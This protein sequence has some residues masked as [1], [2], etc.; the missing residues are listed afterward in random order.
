MTFDPQLAPEIEDDPACRYCDE[1]SERDDLCY[2]HWML[3]D[4]DYA[5]ELRADRAR[6][7]RRGL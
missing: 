3:S 1:P 6:D 5:D 2:H 4:A 7:A